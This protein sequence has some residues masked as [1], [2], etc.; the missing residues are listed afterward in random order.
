M[1]TGTKDTKPGKEIENGIEEKHYFDLKAYLSRIM[2]YSC[3]LDRFTIK[4][5][6]EII[7]ALGCK[8]TL[9]YPIRILYNI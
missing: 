8:L 6:Y 3:L 2:Y 4:L 7:L 9:E 5:T 1:T